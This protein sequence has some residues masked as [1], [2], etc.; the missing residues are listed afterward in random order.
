MNR[1]CSGTRKEQKTKQ[2]RESAASG[3]L[4]DRGGCVVLALRSIRL[5]LNTSGAQSG[6]P[7]QTLLLPIRL[8]VRSPR[9]SLKTAGKSF[10]PIRVTPIQGFLSRGGFVDLDSM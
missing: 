10:R 9:T 8:R 4:G 1:D 2:L 6:K 5:A 3:C 7:G